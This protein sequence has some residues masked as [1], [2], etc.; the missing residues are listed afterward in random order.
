ML[1]WSPRQA[2]TVSKCLKV[3]ELD[4]ID[5]TSSQLPPAARGLVHESPKLDLY[6]FSASLVAE[7]MEGLREAGDVLAHTCVC[8][9][10]SVLN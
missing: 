4:E 7:E 8:Q 6:P 1:R 5:A 2:V 3:S 10:V 9:L